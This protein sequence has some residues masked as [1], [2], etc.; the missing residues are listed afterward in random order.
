[1][2]SHTG[3]STAPH[4]QVPAAA[5]PGL[6]GRPWR[7]NAYAG[8]WDTQQNVFGVVHV[9]TSPNAP[10]TRARFSVLV[11][12]RAVEVVEPLPPGSFRSSSIDVD[13]PAARVLVDHPGVHA[14]LEFTPRF[15]EADYSATGVLPDLVEGISLQHFQQGANV[16]GRIEV[17]GRTVTID[18]QAFRDRTW[19]PR[20]ESAAW[21]EYAVIAGCTPAFDYTVMRFRD[22]RDR[23]ATHGFLIRPEGAVPVDGLALIRDA[24]GMITQATVTGPDA[25]RVLLEMTRGRGG[26]W[27]P[28]G[29][30]GPPPVLSAYDDAVDVSVDGVTGAGF[31]EQAVLRLT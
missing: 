28:M 31:T 17:H 24:A 26:F 30:G 12:G 10:G 15:V 1:M 5:V 9:S 29:T 18:G 25:T 20:D 13:L 23:T 3:L 2:T 4:A 27:V 21:S 8:F 19:G 22:T 14:E 7:D 6:G 11:D 16:V